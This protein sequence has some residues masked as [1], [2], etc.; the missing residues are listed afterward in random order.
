MDHLTK[1][2]RS[3]LMSKIRGKHT[4]PE[5]MVRRFVWGSGYRYRLHGKNLPGTPDLVF[6][7]KW[8]VIFVNGCFWHGHRCRGN[9]LPKTRTAFWKAKIARNKKRD[10]ASVSALRRAGWRCLTV[11]ECAVAK[12]RAMK[13]VLRF[14]EG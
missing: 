13:K 11:W 6:K 3:E 7:S 8:K 10:S 1:V 9:K 12:P 4:K 5:I 14:L 2:Q